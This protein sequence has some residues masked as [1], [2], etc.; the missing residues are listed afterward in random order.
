MSYLIDSQRV[1][2]DEIL[3]M[4]YL[5]DPYCIVAGGAPRDWYFGKEATDIDLFFH[6]PQASTQATMEEML[7]RAGFKVTTVKDGEN[8]PDWYKKNP[9]LQTVYE[10]GIDGVKVQLLRMNKP[11]W[12]SVIDKFPLSI[13]K[14]WY[15][16]G[17]IVL[18]KDFVRSVKFEAIYK[19]NMIYNNEHQYI[20]KVLAKFPQYKYYQSLESLATELLDN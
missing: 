16:N 7:K 18:E 1:V 2:A 6:C 15:K 3:H 19:T 10:T 8:I 13:C 14:A 20:Q 11:T 12:N 9:C 17:K 4:M 5:I